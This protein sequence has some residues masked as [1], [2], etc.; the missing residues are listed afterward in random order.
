MADVGDVFDDWARRGRAEGME[1]GHGKTAAPL[2][3]SLPL[4]PGLD[5]LD[6]GMG[7]G[8]ASRYAAGHGCRAVGI[9]LSQE[10]VDRA[11]AGALAGAKYVQGDFAK[12]PFE[13][14]SFDVA[15]SMEAVYYAPD[16]DAVLREV[17]RVMK[18]GGAFHLLM[19]YYGE[20]EASHGWPGDLDV[21]MSLRSQQEWCDALMEAGFQ[22]AIADRLRATAA[23]AEEWKR[24]EGTLYICAVV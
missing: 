5:F 11:N 9:D 15:W 20:N 3:H 2:L 13:D 10:M 14:A 24:N 22:A 18:P 8:W 4:A 6:L 1:E 19:D 12:L 21:D 7:N 16:P 23:E 17:R